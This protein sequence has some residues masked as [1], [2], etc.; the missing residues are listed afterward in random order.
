MMQLENY[1]DSLYVK[2][3]SAYPQKSGMGT[4]GVEVP[5]GACH[6]AR[7]AARPLTTGIA[8]IVGA[9]KLKKIYEKWG[10][11]EGK[12]G[13]MWWHPTKV[14]DAAKF[15]KPPSGPSDALPVWPPRRDSAQQSQQVSQGFLNRGQ[16]G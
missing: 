1:G 10:F 13:L 4:Q 5:E 11:K 9:K 14:E 2:W 6:Q 3:L 15:S 12:Q 7:R 16:P 8:A